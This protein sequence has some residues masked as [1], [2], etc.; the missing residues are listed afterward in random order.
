[1]IRPALALLAILIGLPS[2]ASAAPVAASPAAKNKATLVKPLSL[3]KTGDLEFGRVSVGAA[4][5]T[6]TINAVSDAR[7]VSG[8]VTLMGGVTLAARFLSYGT[9]GSLLLITRGPLPV[10]TRAGGTETMAVTNLT[11]NGAGIRLIA[12]DGTLDLRVG[13]TLA[14]AANQAEGE[15]AGTFDIYVNYF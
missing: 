5:G 15:Y 6:V 7:T 4:A 9:R 10:L 11:L 14:V 2:S 12:A 3:I 8:G 1:M 13:G